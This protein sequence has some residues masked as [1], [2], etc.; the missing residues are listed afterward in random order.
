MSIF[1]EGSHFVCRTVLQLDAYIL[2]CNVRTLTHPRA[3]RSRGVVEV[4]LRGYRNGGFKSRTLLGTRVYFPWLFKLINFINIAG[5][6]LPVAALIQYIGGKVRHSLP[7]PER[8]YGV[9]FI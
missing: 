3:F 4:R 2:Q 1:K 8:T 7:F 5:I 9:R 6:F